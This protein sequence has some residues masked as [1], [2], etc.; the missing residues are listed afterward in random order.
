MEL[1]N[2]LLLRAIIPHEV[3]E[4]YKAG[5]FSNIK[6][7]KIATQRKEEPA[8]IS[9]GTSQYDACYTKHTPRGA[10][11]ILTTDHILFTNGENKATIRLLRCRGCHKRISKILPEDHDP[12]HLVTKM[13][14][15]DTE[16]HF[17]GEGVYCD[18]IC[19]ERHRQELAAD[20]SRGYIYR[21]AEPAMKLYHKLL[22]GEDEIPSRAHWSLLIEYGGSITREEYYRNRQRYIRCPTLVY[23]PTKVQFQVEVVKW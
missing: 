14:L 16:Y 10:V 13:T 3:M 5:H 8:P 11:R 18:T 7:K 23:S 12:V 6:L 2:S 20:I 17:E 4:K 9:E 21:N 19:A 22:T 1:A 15:K